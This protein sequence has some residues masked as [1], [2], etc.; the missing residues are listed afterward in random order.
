MK[1]KIAICW[2]RRDLRLHDHAALYH[3]LK[4]HEQVLLLFIFDRAILDALEDPRDRRVS[5]IYAVILKIR[6]Q[7][8]ALGS[9]LKVAYGFP[10]QVFTSLLNEYSVTHVYACADYEPYALQRDQSVAALLQ[11]QGIPFTT[12]KDHVL[13]EKGDVVKPDGSAYTVF[14]PYSVKWKSLFNLKSVEPYAVHRFHEHLLQTAPFDLPELSA[15]GF[16]TSNGPFPEAEINIDLVKQYH[17]TR[18]FPGMQGT[19]RLGVHLRFGTVSIREVARHAMDYNQTFLNEL[20]WR[21]FYQQI[22]W[23]YPHVG[24]GHAFKRAYENIQ[25][26]NNENEFTSWCEGKTGYPLVDAGMRELNATGFM[27]NRVRMV[28]ASFLCKHLLIDW[29]WGE[30]Y[31]AGK[32]LDYELA[33]NNGGWQWA[34]GSGCD[35][36]PYF[37]IFNP[38]LQAKKFDGG[39]TYISKWIPELNSFSYPSPIVDHSFARQRAIEAYTNAVRTPA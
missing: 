16:E 38:T 35:A 19:S 12:Y 15:M 37:R 26:R 6:K 5:F 17:V 22:L 23:H 28:V 39:L 3:A 11:G 21:E 7:L 4:N 36:A 18:D 8:A 27:H 33:S 10:E 30:A 34:S 13:F 31:F 32:L 25:W 1:D 24:K 9:S 14:T 20:I 2:L 29:R